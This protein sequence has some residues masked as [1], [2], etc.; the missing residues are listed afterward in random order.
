MCGTC[1]IGAKG[2]EKHVARL[3]GSK[4]QPGKMQRINV[5]KSFKKNDH[6][7]D[8][9]FQREFLALPLMMKS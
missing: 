1:F 4:S 3:H 5:F 7:N 2:L 6:V 8:K 9:I